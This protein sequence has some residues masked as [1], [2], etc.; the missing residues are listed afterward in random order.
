MSSTDAPYASSVL[1]NISTPWRMIV[2]LEGESMINEVSSLTA[3]DFEEGGKKLS[4]YI[5]GKKT[6]L[7]IYVNRIIF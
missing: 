1:K 4:G 3:P 5:V 6:T 2:I 7:L